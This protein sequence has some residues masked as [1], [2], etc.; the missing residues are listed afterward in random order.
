MILIE[1]G[2]VQDSLLLQPLHEVLSKLLS[3]FEVLGIGSALVHSTK[4]SKETIGVETLA[5][6]LINDDVSLGSQF[7]PEQRVVLVD[8]VLSHDG[9]G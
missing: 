6:E 2:C 9:T 1:R 4:V 5:S 8:L 3:V 7:F